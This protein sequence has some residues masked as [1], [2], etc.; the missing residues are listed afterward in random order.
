MDINIVFTFSNL[1]CNE[2][3]WNGLANAFYIFTKDLKASEN[4]N[5]WDYCFRYEVDSL[6]IYVQFFLKRR[7][8]TTLLVF[9]FTLLIEGVRV[10]VFLIREL[11]VM[12]IDA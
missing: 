12:A 2:I 11:N 3:W 8:V 10:K 9:I 5:M 6:Y 7:T 4:T 1:M